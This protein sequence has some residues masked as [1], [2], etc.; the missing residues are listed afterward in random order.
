MNVSDSN[1][2]TK[3]SQ[4]AGSVQGHSYSE[5]VDSQEALELG[6]ESEAIDDLD[7]KKKKE[8]EERA[9]RRKQFSSK[10][11]SAVLDDQE[12]PFELTKDFLQDQARKA[13]NKT[14][15]EIQK[16][17]YTQYQDH[18]KEAIQDDR[19]T[20]FLDNVVL[21]KS[22][23][24]QKK[25]KIEAQIA[26]QQRRESPKEKEGILKNYVSHYSEY[27]VKKGGR[28]KKEIIAL[29]QQMKR[30]G[31]SQSRLEHI[32]TFVSK[33]LGED[34]HR[35]L[36]N[37]FVTLAF[38]YEKKV[39]QPEFFKTHKELNELFKYGHET[40]LLQDNARNLRELKGGSEFE[41][42][43]FVESE[44]NETLVRTRLKTESMDQ[45]AREFDLLNN[46]A[47][48]SKFDAKEFFKE[49]HKKLDNM[50]LQRFA[51]PDPKG[52]LDTE[53]NERASREKEDGKK[54]ESSGDS[55]E[56]EEQVERAI[57]QL[58]ALYVRR[59]TNK[60][61]LDALKL[62]AQ[63]KK[64]ESRVKTLNPAVSLEEI[65]KKALGLSKLKLVFMLR[66]AY[67]KR[68]TMKRHSGGE[69]RMLQKEFKFITE[70]LKTCA[71]PLSKSYL[72]EVRDSANRSIFSL[73]KE[74]YLKLEVHIEAG[75]GN[76]SLLKKCEEYKA[77]LV[78]LKKE[79]K[80]IEDV[81]SKRM[82]DLDFLSDLN[83]IE[84]A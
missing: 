9:K 62:T 28:Y 5:S 75:G 22:G 18:L 48:F 76:P 41:L 36:K 37:T 14:Q 10:S 68:A 39:T 34:L 20:K 19:K 81:K 30:K 65:Q 58:R 57:E 15:K 78:R 60:G 77:I 12:K 38:Q 71:V 70:K 73:I 66:E 23:E 29:Q 3:A 56:D 27:L 32:N 67:E 8:R 61:W 33:K 13:K 21:S 52:I 16:Q 59:D 45:L 35:R 55:N 64:Q 25:E 40:G 6:G 4:Y 1:R 69:Y 42:K 53:S 50:G 46:I 49:F 63:I 74:E 26:S 80:I 72:K 43:N 44:L 83:V 54:E 17:F 79:T 7:K 24:V 31:F 11:A 2:S 84:A 47:S 51:S 82:N